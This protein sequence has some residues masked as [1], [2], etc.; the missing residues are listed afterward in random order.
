MGIG[1]AKSGKIEFS[2]E[3]KFLEDERVYLI[4]LYG[5]GMPL[6]NNSFAYADI[7]GLVPTIQSVTVVGVVSTD[8]VV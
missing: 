3:Y 7:S 1:T 8:E 5:Q 6:D 2:D 4:K